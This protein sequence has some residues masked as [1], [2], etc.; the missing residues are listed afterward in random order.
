MLRRGYQAARRGP[1]RT[2]IETGNPLNFAS[3]GLRCWVRDDAGIA[4]NGSTV[5]Q[6]SDQ[7]G[8]GNH[9]PQATA[10]RQPTY[11]GPGDGVDFDGAD[12]ALTGPTLSGLISASAFTVFVVFSA[13]TVSTNGANTWQN[14]A[15]IG[16]PSAFFGI[17]LKSAPNANVFNWDGSDDKATGAIAL[18]TRT[19]LTARHGSGNLGMR[20]N[21]GAEATAAS[22]DTTVLSGATEMGRGNN[23][24]VVCYDGKIYE[25]VFFNTHLPDA[26]QA[27]I[28]AYL[29]AR[30]RVTL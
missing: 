3:Q 7:S 18:M 30:N 21:N 25:V 14:S 26:D 15:L 17:H 28:R 27:L 12:T 5:S 23:S 13:D 6:W 10:T 20:V 22:G 16:Q 9:W 2:V 24:D 4:L 8:A 1:S 19:I 29:A 11:G